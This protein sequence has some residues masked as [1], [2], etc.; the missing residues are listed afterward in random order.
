MVGDIGVD[1]AGRVRGGG[2]RRREGGA[3][4]A[5]AAW[6]LEGEC[7]LVLCAPGPV[8]GGDENVRFHRRERFTG[9]VAAR[10]SHC[11]LQASGSCN[12]PVFY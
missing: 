11:Q 3:P 9:A 12:A 2:R 5:A 10:A 1:V 4:S 8:S 7:L 6:N